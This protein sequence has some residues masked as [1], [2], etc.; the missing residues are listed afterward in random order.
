MTGESFKRLSSND[1]D[2]FYRHLYDARK[3]YEVAKN[4]AG[5]YAEQAALKLEKVKIG[6][7][8]DAFKFY[9]SG[10]LPPAHVDRRAGRWT[11]KM[12][13][14]HMHEAWWKHDCPEKPYPLL[15]SH[16]HMGHVKKIEAPF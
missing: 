7:D 15:F 1:E 4:E 14:S 10:K 16:A 5:D 8:T 13:I 2:A 3:A 6:K 12:F 11:A 9:S